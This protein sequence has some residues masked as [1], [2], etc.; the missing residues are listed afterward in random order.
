MNATKA[1]NFWVASTLV[2]GSEGSGTSFWT[3]NVVSLFWKIVVL[4]GDCLGFEGKIWT[5]GFA[6]GM[7]SQSEVD[8]VRI[9]LLL[10]L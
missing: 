9:E 8:F 2:D 5:F 6:G 3:S 1:D 4:E 7:F 10:Y